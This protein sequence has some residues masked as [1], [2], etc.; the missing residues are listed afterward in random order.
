MSRK[1]LSPEHYAKALLKLVGA[2]QPVRL[3]DVAKEIGLRIRYV[4]SSGFDG[5][6][7]RLAGLPRG[8]I[9]VRAS[10][11]KSRRRFTTAHEIG[12]YVLPGHDSENSV[13][14]A[15]DVGQLREDSDSLEQA[16]N[17]FAGELL[18]PS[19]AVRRI[20]KKFGVSMDTCKFISDQ[21]EVS[22]TAAAV[23][24]VEVTDRRA[25]LVVTEGGI[26]KRFKP[27]SRITEFIPIGAPLSPDSLAS[28]LSA[29]HRKKDGLVPADAW[30]D[31]SLSDV[32][33]M[34]DSLLM[35]N[36][37]KILTLLTLP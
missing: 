13:C 25:A 9:A 31:I 20:V 21:F 23:K 15:Q 22:L 17:K 16:A 36:Y 26:R 32:M 12:H 10:M 4:P 14:R 28:Q 34:E 24:C 18:M 33:I 6:L 30:I 27:S 19:L 1:R 11:E 3:A 7:V 5:A 2:Q 29:S 8:R 37:E 35:P